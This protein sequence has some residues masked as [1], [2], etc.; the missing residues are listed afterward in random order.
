M[1][2]IAEQLERLDVFLARNLPQHSRTKLRKFI[3][4]GGVKVNGKVEKPS[5]KLEPGM[6]VTMRQP[7]EAPRHDLT[8]ADI[9]LDVRYEDDD[10]LVVNKPRAL[11][12]PPAYSLKAPSLVNAL[13][14]RPHPLSKTAGTFRPGIVHRLDKETTGLLVVAKNDSAHS[15]L[16]RQ[17]ERK[18]AERRYFA[19]VEGELEHEVMTINARLGRDQRDR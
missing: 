16:A 1:E 5:F 19:I 2:F 13:L 7:P 10:L 14:A 9:P 12:T 11:A 3:T 18:D 15:S 6:M 8:P 17:I 4:N